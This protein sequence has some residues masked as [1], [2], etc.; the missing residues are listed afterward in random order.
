VHPGEPVLCVL[1]PHGLGVEDRSEAL[2]QPA[3]DDEPLRVAEDESGVRG[4]LARIGADLA[5][6]GE[7]PDDRIV[8][9]LGRAQLG[10]GLGDRVGGVVPF[11][12]VGAL[13]GLRDR[14]V[15]GGER[16]P[17]LLLGV[18]EVE[19]TRLGELPAQRRERGGIRSALVAAAARRVATLPNAER[20][21]AAARGASVASVAAAS[22]SS[23]VRVAAARR[24]R[25]PPAASI[26]AAACS[27]SASRSAARRERVPEV[28]A[29]CTAVRAVTRALRASCTAT[30]SARSRCAASSSVRAWVERKRRIV[31]RAASISRK[32]RSSACL[33]PATGPVPSSGNCAVVAR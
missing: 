26:P 28:S 24:S 20:T 12:R 30:G 5:Q 16:R 11:A 27:A 15:D 13:V 23:R 6:V 4:E 29:A 31:S 8:R 32:A 22:A 9:L 33:A 19:R 10:A 2:D 7:A 3:V 18:G 14:P 21:P 25:T 1:Q 17:R